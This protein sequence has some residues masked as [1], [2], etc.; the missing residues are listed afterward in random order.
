M[1]KKNYISALFEKIELEE[2][3]LAS[4]DGL[5]GDIEDFGRDRYEDTFDGEDEGWGWND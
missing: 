1:N 2:I 4:G 5:S 3:L